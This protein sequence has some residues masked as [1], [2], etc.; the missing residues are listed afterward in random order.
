MS[1]PLTSDVIK[2]FPTAERESFFQPLSLP[3]RVNGLPTD[4]M[5][6]RLVPST[7]VLDSALRS[8]GYSPLLELTVRN[9][10]TVRLLFSHLRSRWEK[11]CQ[12]VTGIFRL[13]IASSST[14][15]VWV[16]NRTKP[17]ETTL[18]EGMTVLSNSNSLLSNRMEK[19]S[20]DVMEVCRIWLID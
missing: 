8:F 4:T 7:D 13:V 1:V 5:V 16:E 9:T 18:R 12:R 14:A 17:I 10:L 20:G 6:I 2:P 11:F 19:A 15:G 3:R